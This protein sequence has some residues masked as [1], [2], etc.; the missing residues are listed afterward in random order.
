ML[1]R[2]ATG[3]NEEREMAKQAVTTVKENNVPAT[4]ATGPNAFEAYGQSVSGNRIVGDLLKFSKGEYLAGQNGDEVDMG[5][6]VIAIM[7]SFCVGWVKW[8]DGKPVDYRMGPLAEGFVPPRRDTL[9]DDDEDLWEVD[10]KGKSRDPW[11][12]S[13]YVVLLEQGGDKLY[14]FTTSSKGGMGAL[15]KVAG[16]YGKNIRMKPDDYPVLSLSKD[17][18]KHPNKEYGWIHVPKFDV[19]AWVNRAEADAALSADHAAAEAAPKDEEDIP[20]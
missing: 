4:V 6:R 13:N 10:D 18:Y 14:T 1:K 2:P 12:L 9:G 3:Q 7:Q 11:Q 16:A 19:V 20:F 15:G 5:T 17:K 8:Q